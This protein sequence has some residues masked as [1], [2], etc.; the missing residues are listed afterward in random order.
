MINK[1]IACL[2]TIVLLSV[3]IYL[4][5]ANTAP[6][7][8]E[9]CANKL[10]IDSAQHQYWVI[11][12]L[13]DS[14]ANLN[15][16]EL[17]FMKENSMKGTYLELNKGSSFKRKAMNDD[18]YYLHKG[19]CTVQFDNR[20]QSFIAGDIIYLKKGSELTIEDS[21]E[22]LQL[23]IVSMYLSSNSA[24]PKWKH[25]PQKSMESPRSPKENSWNPFIMYSNVMLGLYMLPHSLDGDQRLVH[26][27]QELNIVTVGSSKFVMDSGTIDVEKGSIFFVEEGNGHYF[28]KLDDNIDILILWEMRNVDHSKHE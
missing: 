9:L 7:I 1:L 5:Q 18:L 3:G 26:E 20:N 17:I 10:P 14:L 16:E 15:A 24:K 8:P 13:S 27:W 25:F 19:S 11:A 21:D 28:D 23:V 22:P 12:K 4:L 6:Y 2:S